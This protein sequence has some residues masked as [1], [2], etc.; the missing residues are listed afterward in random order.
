MNKLYIKISFFLLA[1]LTLSAAQAQVVNAGPDIY[2]PCNTNCT[3]ISASIQGI[4]STSCSTYDVCSIPYSGV[5]LPYNTGTPAFNTGVNIDDQWSPVISLPFPFTFY[6]QQFTSAIISSNGELSFNTGNAGAFSYWQALNIPTGNLLNN[7]IVGYHRDLYATPLYPSY[8]TVGTTPNRKFIVSYYNSPWFGGGGNATFQIVL[9]ETTNIIETYIASSGNTQATI[10]IQRNSTTGLTPTGR[11]AATFNPVQE[12]WRFTPY[13]SLNFTPTVNLTT[14]GGLIV[15]VGVPVPVGSNYTVNFANVCTTQDTTSYVV[16]ATY[17]LCVGNQVYK[18]T[19]RIIKT[20]TP[21]PTV[22]SPVVICQNSTPGPLQVTGT[23]ILWYTQAVGGAGSTTQPPVNTSVPGL[24]TVWVTQTINSCESVRVPIY[25]TVNPTPTITATSNSPVCAGQS[26]NF[27]ATLIPGASYQWNGPVGFTP[28]VYNPSIGTA[29]P[30]NA[31]TYSVTAT[32]TTIV[33]GVSYT[34]TSAQATTV[35]Q[36]TPNPFIAFASAQSATTCT[37][38]G[39]ITL[40]GLAPNTSYVVNYSMNGVPQPSATILSTNLGQVLI[41][42]L[43]PGSYTA[44]SVT[45]GNC[46]SNTMAGPYVINN[47]PVGATIAETHINPTTCN[48]SNGSITLTGL[49]NG[50]SYYINYTKNGVAQ[51]QLTQT[52]VGGTVTI[53]ALT[54]G[55]YTN[56]SVTIVS[57]GCISNTIASVILVD[58]NSTSITVTSTNPTGCNTNT[59]SI[60]ISGLTSGGSYTINYIK[61]GVAQPSITF[62]ATGT[63][64]TIPSLGAGTYTGITVTL[65]GCVSNIATATLVDPT[66]PVITLVANSPTS[67]TVNNGSIVISGLVTGS[68]YVITY[69]KNGVAQPSITQTAVAGNVTISGLG[70]GSYTAITVVINSCV[71]NTLTATLVNPAAPVIA[72]TINNPTGCNAANGS[73]VITGLTTGNSYVVNYS[74]NGIAQPAITQTATSGSVTIPALTSGNYTGITVTLNGCI[75]NIATATLVDPSGPVISVSVN[76][77]TGCNTNNG[78]IVISTLTNGSSYI[79]NYIKNGVAQPSVTQTASGGSVTISGLGAGSYTGITVTFNGCMS[80]AV[81]ATLVNPAG[82]VITSTANNPTACATATGSIIL[83]GLITGSSYTISYSKNGT[84]QPVITQT[85]AGGSVTIP[86]LTSGTYTNI[87]VTLNGCVSN[88]LGPITLSDPSAPATPVVTGNGPLCPGDTLEL[89]ATSTTVGVS[90]QWTGPAGPPPFNSTLPNPTVPNIQPSQAGLYSVTASLNGCVSAAGTYLLV[91]NP[92][93]AQPNAGPNLTVCAGN[94][95]NLT[96]TTTTPGITAWTWTSNTTP[97]FTSGVQNPTIT[98]ATV[99]NTGAYYVTA[100]AQGCASVADTVLVTVVPTP[101]IQ[102]TASNPTTCGG[103][104]GSIVLNTLTNGS[105]YVINY[106]KNGTAQSPIT[107]TASS[108][109]VTIPG[110]GAGTYTNITVTLNGCASNVVGPVVITDPNLP[111]SPVASTAGIV[112]EGDTVFLFASTVAGASYTWTGPAGF[113]ETVQNPTITP[114]TLAANGTYSVTATVAGCT[115]LP[116]TVLVEIKPLP[117]VPSLTTNAP[118]CEG[119]VLS[120]NSNTIPGVTYEWSGPGFSVN[121]TNEDETLTNAQTN[122]S[123]TY[124]LVVDNGYCTSTNS[125]NVI[126]NPIPLAP[127]TTDVEVCQGAIH[128]LTAQGQ[129][130]KWYTT[131]VGGFSSQALNA[132]TITPGDSTYYVS[133]T[134]N[135]CESPRAPITVTV[136][137]QPVPPVGQPDYVYCQFEAATQL[138][139]TGTSLQWYDAGYNPLPGAPTPNTQVA[140]PQTFFVTQTNNGCE[141]DSTRINGL[142][143]A[144]PGLPVVQQITLCQDDPAPVLN[145]QGQNLQWYSSATGGTGTTVVPVVST[146]NTGTF[147]YY[148]SQTVTNCES[149]RALLRVVVNPKVVADFSTDKD[150]VCDSYPLNVTF[151]GIAPQ[152]AVYDWNFD[153]ASEVTGSGAGPY[154]VVWPTEGARTIT[155][156]VTNLNCTSTITKTIQ[157]LPTLKPN[158]DLPLDACV[159]EEVRVQVGWDQMNLPGYLWA[160]GDATVV[161][162]A[163]NTPGPITLKWNA[164]G[165]HYVSLSLTNIPCPSLPKF[166]TINIHQPVAKIESTSQSEICT[167]DSVLFSAQPG[168]DYQYQWTPSAFFSKTGENL[169]IWGVVKKRSYVT[170]TVTDRWGCTN[171]DSILVEPKSCCE[172]FMPN[173]FT[174]NGDGKNDVFRMVTKGNQEISAFIIVDRWG[175]RVFESLNQNEG[176]DGSFHG[177]AQ[178]IGTYQYFLRYRCADTKEIM[179]MKGDV[180]L[181]R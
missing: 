150:T 39:Q 49:T 82:P 123:G 130:L 62:T 59:G 107:Q 11:N 156:T 29:Q 153:G 119:D 12:A 104:N 84:A 143:N 92:A 99:A 80:N 34:C 74:K 154:V 173:T 70:A 109:D 24:D 40:S 172:V 161:A 68:S 25:I 159:G 56:I 98:P 73:I 5:N 116:G 54:A 176:W 151:T 87:T 79:I 81:V 162:G 37:G 67:C 118:L 30:V 141:S 138:Q 64:Y 101:A 72:V 45:I 43:S 77:P 122:Y 46:T 8:R 175:K 146:A 26:V 100:T 142:I 111:P 102:F 21:P 95:I 171:S 9:Y 134:I 164:T 1:F 110:L 90:Y 91:I 181:L 15:Q 174:P 113:S 63:S 158:F 155:L 112:C 14:L 57:N 177:E 179:E 170:L 71:S 103:T 152:G 58:P 96:A 85:A 78:S 88:V 13:S 23:N 75:S 28:I 7:S 16:E 47:P 178:D 139:A 44:I 106:S 115:S 136:K 140:G 36:V 55:T 22:V 38:F 124:T 35:L 114:V 105:S 128:Q 60:T 133:Q 131:P 120:L 126:V 125:I 94:A 50:T 61:N 160:F 66:P 108:G 121:G 86:A 137:P 3:P 165:Q 180:M 117:A 147:D 53:P 48:G 33:N 19:I 157:V 169:S 27:L 32:I 18:D 163:S 168:L 144:K 93:P 132:S 4:G 129:N 41:Q 76:N 89:T 10:G 97:A 166:D 135:G 51:P 42:N 167:S 6:C 31:G 52:A 69:S 148:V 20:V 65:N 149:D 2:L 83:S 17:P 127:V 145:A